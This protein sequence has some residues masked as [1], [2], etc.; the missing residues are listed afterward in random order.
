[1]PDCQSQLILSL[2]MGSACLSF[3]CICTSTSSRKYP[4][5]NPSLEALGQWLHH[6][7]HAA[8][9]P[10][11]DHFHWRSTTPTEGIGAGWHFQLQIRQRLLCWHR[12][13]S[14]TE[15]SQR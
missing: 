13:W 6:G 8:D 12:L 10:T 2:S 11:Q 4:G 1:M 15:V 9:W 3:T 5:A 7:P 14:W